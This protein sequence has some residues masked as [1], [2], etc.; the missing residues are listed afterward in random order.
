MN[1]SDRKRVELWKLRILVPLLLC[2]FLG[3]I[4]GGF[5]HVGIS[6]WSGLFPSLILLIVGGFYFVERKIGAFKK[7]QDFYENV[8]F[9][10]LIFSL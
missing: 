3:G 6:T 5:A 4:V 7:M 10:F 8:R 2:Y 1:R 9:L